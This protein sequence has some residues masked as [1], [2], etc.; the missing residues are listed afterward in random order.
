[1]LWKNIILILVLNFTLCFA[2]DLNIYFLNVGEGDSIFIKT[3]KNHNILI[4]SGNLIT[5]FRVVKFLK[6]KNIKKIDYLIITHPHPDHCGGVFAIINNFNV[7]HKFDNGENL[8]VNECDDLYR[9]YGEIFRKGNY[10][11][12]KK[13][14]RLVIDNISLNVLSPEKISGNWNDDSLVFMVKYKKVK[15]LLM[16]DAGKRIEANLLKNKIN[17]HANILK[18]GHHGGKDATSEKFLDAV[19]PQY[20]VISINKNNIR[21]YPSKKV[22]NLIE[23]KGI[24][25]FTTFDNGTIHF[26]TNGKQLVLKQH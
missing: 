10:N 13:G 12:L 17:L 1:M 26:V 9:W 7:I 18:V 22:V 23:R 20:A 14:D 15:I 4:D 3:P 21:G 5:G 16:A 2:K 11:I 24:V 25:L 6:N 8:K 19:N